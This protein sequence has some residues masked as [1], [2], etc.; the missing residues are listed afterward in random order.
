MATRGPYTKTD[1]QSRLR[2]RDARVK[3]GFTQESLAEALNISQPTLARWERGKVDITVKQL[4]QLA[5]ILDVP[6]AELVE[7][8]D[9][10]TDR[11]RGLIQSLRSSPRFWPIV[12]STLDSLKDAFSPSL[13][14]A[15]E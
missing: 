1:A 14:P 10:L 6:P 4:L 7:D 8:G 12:A 15:A 3:A 5:E 2:I 9:G 11:E 13:P